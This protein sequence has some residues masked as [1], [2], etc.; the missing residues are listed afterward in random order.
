MSGNTLL[1]GVSHVLVDEVHERTM[2]SDFLLAILKD[3]TVVREQ[4]GVPLKVDIP[5]C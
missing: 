2:Q 3:L 1:S 5:F 4:M